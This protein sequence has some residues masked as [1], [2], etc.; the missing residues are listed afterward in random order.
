M[1]FVAWVALGFAV[2]MAVLDWLR[3]V[4]GSTFLEF[5]GRTATTTALLVAAASL[6]VARDVSWGCCSLPWWRVCCATCS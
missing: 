5:V 4:R 2:L 6:D 1:T 3:V